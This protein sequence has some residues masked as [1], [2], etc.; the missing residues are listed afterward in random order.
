MK[1]V[2]LIIYYKVVIDGERAVRTHHKEEY[3]FNDIDEITNIYHVNAIEQHLKDKHS[4]N[5]IEITGIV[6]LRKE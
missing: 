6:P 1:Q 4:A 5:L 2:Y 3:K